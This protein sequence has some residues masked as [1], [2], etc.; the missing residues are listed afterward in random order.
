MNNH[1]SNVFY[2]LVGRAVTL[3]EGSIKFKNK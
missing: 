1:Q 3:G 2:Y